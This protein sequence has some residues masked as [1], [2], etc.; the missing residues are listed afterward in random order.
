MRE[1]GLE[2]VEG[3]ETH[4]EVICGRDDTLCVAGACTLLQHKN[5]PQQLCLAVF[6]WEKNRN[7]RLF[8]IDVLSIM[9]PEINQIKQ[10]S[11]YH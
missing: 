10:T 8:I 9:C 1:G 3:R 7:I 2:V 5:T 6:R 4:K 11:V